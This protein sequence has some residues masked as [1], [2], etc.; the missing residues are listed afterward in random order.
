MVVHSLGNEVT[1]VA[2]AV[3]EKVLGF[4]EEEA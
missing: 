1:S 3:T 4:L 2:R